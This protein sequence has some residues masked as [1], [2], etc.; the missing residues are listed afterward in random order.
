MNRQGTQYW[1]FPTTFHNALKADGSKIT[2]PSEAKMKKE[3]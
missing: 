1:Q 2:Q 3:F